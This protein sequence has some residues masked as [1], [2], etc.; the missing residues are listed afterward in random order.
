MYSYNVKFNII[1]LK[2]DHNQGLTFC[3][4]HKLSLTHI[5]IQGTHSVPTW[6]EG[7]LL[8][9]VLSTWERWSQPW[10]V[11]SWDMHH[12]YSCMDSWTDHFKEAAYTTVLWSDGSWCVCARTVRQGPAHNLKLSNNAK[13]S[14][15]STCTSHVV[16]VCTGA[17]RAGTG[18]GN[19][20]EKIDKILV[21]LS[22]EQTSL[23]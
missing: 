15:N 16:W 10:A 1:L 8:W 18:G 22:Q 3:P 7:M 19:C 21:F 14:Q 4:P 12:Q 20:L 11:L 9:C 6:Q 23:L 13:R 5:L 2:L 17:V